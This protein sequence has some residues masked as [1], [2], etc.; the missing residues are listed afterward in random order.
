MTKVRI[1][2]LA[3]Q[4]V[5]FIGAIPL[6]EKAAPNGVATLGSDRKVPADQLPLM[7][8]LEELEAE[9]VEAEARAKLYVDQKISQILQPPLPTLADLG[10]E[11]EGAEARAKLYIDQQ[12]ASLVARLNQLEADYPVNHSHF[13]GTGSATNGTSVKTWSKFVTSGNDF[14]RYASVASPANGDT[15]EFKFPLKAGNYNLELIY[16]RRTDSGIVNLYLDGSQIGTIDA[17]SSTNSNV[18][19]LILNFSVTTTGIH[20]FKLVVAGKNA[21]SSG[22]SFAATA[23][24]INPQTV[25]PSQLISSVRINCGDQSNY[26]AADGNVWIADTYF[27]GGVRADLEAALGPFTVAGTQ[28]QRIYKFERSQDNGSFSYA[29]PIGGSGIF[30]LKLLFAENYFNN[31]GDR[32]GSVSLN[33]SPLL[34]N[35][36]ILKEVNKHT[37]LVKAWTGVQMPTATVNL[38]FTNILVN[39]IELVRT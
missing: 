18:N 28:N 10:G 30:T 38:T 19:R 34:T 5:Q 23:V 31:V 35:F 1:E 36:D 6:T 22:F 15:V 37:A 7:P 13:W 25:I 16:L 24:L 3:P 8:T 39:G 9:A 20:S 14:C 32:V 12:I 26:T 17:Y 11:P 21:S 29:I 33:G 27:T 2:G 4:D